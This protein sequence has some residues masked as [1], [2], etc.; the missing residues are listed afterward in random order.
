MHSSFIKNILDLI[1]EHP[2][3]GPCT[4][5]SSFNV[6]FHIG[7]INLFCHSTFI[8]PQRNFPYSLYGLT[9]YTY[10]HS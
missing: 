4:V 10:I 3:D 1:L 5:T 8:Q 7:S 2:S 9:I 6:V